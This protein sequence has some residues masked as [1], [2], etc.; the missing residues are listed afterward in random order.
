MRPQLLADLHRVVAAGN[1]GPVLV[2]ELAD[3]VSGQIHFRLH[4]GPIDVEKLD[5]FL[6]NGQ[7]YQRLQDLTQLYV[8]PSMDFSITYSAKKPPST[9]LAE[10]SYLG[11]RSWLGASLLKGDEVR[12]GG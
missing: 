12:V 1:F 9:Q 11:W 8:G 10:K 2:H 5:L 4:L 7:G 6:P 3:P